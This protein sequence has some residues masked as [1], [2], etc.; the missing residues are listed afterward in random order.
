MPPP[1]HYQF[2]LRG[3]I[4]RGTTRTAN[5]QLAE[6]I[7][8]TKRTKAIERFEGVADMPDVLLSKHVDHYVAHTA[9]ANTTSYKDRAVLDALREIVG[10]DRPI[11]EVTAFPLNAGSR[12][13]PKR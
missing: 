2:K 7:A 13:E 8:H 3:R 9:Q 5:R 4:H 6:R 11:R 10:A 12:R 1:W